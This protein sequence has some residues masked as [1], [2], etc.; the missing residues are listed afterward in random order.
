MA[1]SGT[2]TNGAKTRRALHE[3]HTVIR[4]LQDER[5]REVT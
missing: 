1:T 5:K 3:L 4:D 2:S